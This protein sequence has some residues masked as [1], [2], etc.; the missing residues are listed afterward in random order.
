M[1]EIA[2]DGYV[3]KQLRPEKKKL[4]EG[5]NIYMLENA[6]DEGYNK[7]CD[8]WE[9]WLKAAQQ[10]IKDINVAKGWLNNKEREYER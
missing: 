2:K 8:D 4:Q 5:T 1:K 9:K 3:I 6:H 7:A 10:S